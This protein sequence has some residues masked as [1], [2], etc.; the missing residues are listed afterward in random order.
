VKIT[1][2]DI[3]AIIIGII[4]GVY[5]TG[6]IWYGW[7][8]YSYASSPQAIIDSSQGGETIVRYKDGKAMELVFRPTE[9]KPMV[10]K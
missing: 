4:I 10:K 5:H 1:G 3:I 8:K 6:A 9:T 2:R 7:Y